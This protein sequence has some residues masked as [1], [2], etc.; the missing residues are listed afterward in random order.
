MATE[1]EVL[2]RNTMRPISWLHISDIHMSVRDAWSQ[3]VVLKA[4]CEH[5]ALQRAK[6]MAAD[7]ILVTGDLAFSGK[8]SEYE[9][10][11]EFFDA[12]RTASGV[13]K[14]RMFCIPGNHDI[15]R[16]RQGLCFLG[17][18][19]S[20]QDQNRI[21]AV[22]GA[23]E[24]LQTLLKRQ[25]S[26]RH[27]QNAYF[28]GQDRTR[29]EDGLG[30]V[31]WLTVEDVRLAIIGLDS[32][33]LAQGGITDHGKL[34][35]G[36]RQ[37]INAVRLAQESSDPAHITIAMAHH[38]FH[39][40]QEFD[41]RPVMSRIERT[42]HFLHCGHLH[43]PEARTTGS[44]GTGCLTLGA[45]AS[46][47]TRQSYNSYA[48]V[49]LDL[50]RAVRT[51]KTLQYD[52]VVGSF[53][54]GSS[55]EYRIEVTP[56]DTCSVNELAVAMKT[57][58][59]GLAPWAHYLSALLL[60]RKAELPIPAQNGHT[61][62]SFGVLQELP[63]SDLKCKTAGFMAFRNALRVLYGRV[64]RLSDILDRHGA[65]V[66]R[67]G[68]ILHKLCEADA[69]LKNRLDAQESDARALASTTP[70]GSFSHTNALLTELAAAQEWVLLREQAQ[71]HVVSLDPA[72]AILAKQ[73]LALSLANSDETADKETAIELYWSLAGAESAKF[74]DVGNLAALLIEAGELDKARTAVLEGIRDFPEKA[75][76]FAEIG[77]KIV[78]ETGDRDFRQQMEVAIAKRGKSD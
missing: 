17:A 1:Y 30:Y 76:Y 19:A 55:E 12:L 57:Y 65:A 34:L 8:A 40:L 74:S 10:V 6:G 63:D 70:P 62:A 51:S 4:M 36:E 29:T 58:D 24:D 33:W 75:D 22:L 72:V 47:K 43:E 32:A 67:Y 5:I 25:E 61:F 15:D 11:A 26:Y 49:T 69:A 42:C 35:V 16:D 20:L 78:E 23:G 9:L 53:S 73:L 28:A 31:S 38:P 52:P 14:E 18:R 37:V 7:F 39:L 48:I 68:A 77:Q 54:F 56:A 44:S 2:P 41:R 27:F 3:D 64:V 46:Y 66:A 50:L 60:D 13:P 59:P 45:G 21:D 71:R